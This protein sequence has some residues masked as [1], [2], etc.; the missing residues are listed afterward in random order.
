MTSAL[1]CSCAHQQ[2]FNTEEFNIMDTAFTP[3]QSL[4]GGALIGL[5]AVLMMLLLGKIMGA[6]GILSGALLPAGEG[7]RGWRLA[8]LLGMVSSPLVYL[9]ISG[10]RPTVDVP[11]P[12]PLII[13]GGVLVG[14]GVTLGSGCTSGHG[15]CGLA[16]LSKRSAVAVAI[17]M[18]CT[19]ITVYVVRHVLSIGA[20]G[21]L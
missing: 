17:F 8:T 20:G 5:A 16:R 7:E 18:I 19:F 10:A 3:L 13:V 15:V 12:T 4:L 6:T 1:S 2:A 21:V 9:L 11:L 14:I